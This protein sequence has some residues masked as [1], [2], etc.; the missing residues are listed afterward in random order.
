MTIAQSDAEPT[1]AR[2]PQDRPRRPQRLLH[3][4][5]KTVYSYGDQLLFELVRQTF[6]SFGGGGFFDVTSRIPTGSRP[7]RPGSTRSTRTSTE[8]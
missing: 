2:G 5:L 7:R 3:L 4:D 6:N 8:W 1:V